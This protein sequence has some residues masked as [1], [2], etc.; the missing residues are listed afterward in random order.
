MNLNEKSRL[1]S[2]LLTL[3]FG[4]LGLFYSSIAGAFVLCIVA[5]FT[6]GTIIVPI[7]CWLLAIGIGDHCVYKHNLNI[8]QIKEL[9]VK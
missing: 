3:F 5:F 4:P 9:M 7:I 1:V 8:Q 2:F 6:A